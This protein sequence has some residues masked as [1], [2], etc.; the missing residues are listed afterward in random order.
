MSS[1]EKAVEKQGRAK[2]SGDSKNEALPEADVAL[3]SPQIENRKKRVDVTVSIL[4]VLEKNGMLTPDLKDSRQAEEYRIIKRPLLSNASAENARIIERGNVIMVTSALQG[5][6]KTYTTT[7]LAVS[8]AAERDRSVLVVD[9]DVVKHSLSSM[10]G[11]EGR[12]GLIDVLL[13]PTTSIDDVIV[14]TDIPS[15]KIIPAGITNNFSTELLASNQMT[16][17]MDKMV[18]RH[19]DRFLILDSPPLL[20]TSQS[21]VLAEHAGQIL[22]VVEEGVTPQKAVIEAIST[23]DSNKAIGTVLNKRSRMNRGEMYGYYYGSYGD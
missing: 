23:L 20:M 19:S 16:Q 4:A 22:V 14:S 13:D 17:I 11:L 9:C 3:S 8:I 15:L 7:N 21:A 2:G 10:F 12:K 6:G 1:I 18:G 5:E